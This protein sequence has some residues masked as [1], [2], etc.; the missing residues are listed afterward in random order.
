MVCLQCSN[1]NDPGARFCRKCGTPLQPVAQH[2][3][4]PAPHLSPDTAPQLPKPITQPYHSPVQRDVPKNGPLSTACLTLGI[5]AM[6]TMLVGLIPCLGWLNYFVLMGGA[7]GKVLGIVALITE[8][9]EPSRNKTIIG[10]ILLFVAIA[11]GSIR[12]AIGGGCV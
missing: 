9:A 3:Y 11:S 12:L 2:E 10:L 4:Q 1:P 8:Q 7:L 5:I 6:S